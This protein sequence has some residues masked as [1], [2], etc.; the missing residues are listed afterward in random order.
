MDLP[1]FWNSPWHPRENNFI[2]M[3]TRKVYARERENLKKM[4][5]HDLN[6]LIA[7]IIKKFQD[8][9]IF[10]SSYVCETLP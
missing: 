5:M 2:L 7:L 6:L 10:K 3:F 9:R 4:I 1:L 8:Y